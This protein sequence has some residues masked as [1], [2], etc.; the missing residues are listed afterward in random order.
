MANSRFIPL[1]LG[2]IIQPALNIINPLQDIE[3]FA[4]ASQ[5][6]DGP[7]LATNTYA[8]GV[9][10]RARIQPISHDLI[11]KHNL[12]FGHVY[13]RFY[14]LQDQVQ[15]PDRN[16][17]NAGDYFEYDGLQWRVMRIPDEFLSGWQE[18]ICMQS[19]FRAA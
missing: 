19:T 15:T 17:S 9:T 6:V 11:F 4:Y 18:I 16:I 10:L 2:D 12:E 3:W 1:R 13:K 14:V 8:D 5:T 7:G